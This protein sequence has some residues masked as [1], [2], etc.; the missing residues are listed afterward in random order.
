MER[1]FDVTDTWVK[2]HSSYLET[3]R[4][5]KS[6]VYDLPNLKNHSWTDDCQID[7]IKGAFR[8]EIEMLLVSD[9]YDDVEYLEESDESDKDN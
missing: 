6:A 9:R 3:P 5:I 2:L 7:W 4:R 8:T 1:Q